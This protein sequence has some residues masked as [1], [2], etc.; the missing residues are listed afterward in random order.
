MAAT[1]S[2]GTDYINCESACIM[3]MGID[4]RTLN[5]ASFFKTTNGSSFR[6]RPHDETHR[7][8]IGSSQW[9]SKVFRKL[10]TPDSQQELCS[11]VSE[12][13]A[14]ADTKISWNVVKTVKLPLHFSVYHHTSITLRKRFVDHAPCAIT[15][16]PHTTSKLVSTKEISKFQ[17]NLVSSSTLH[18]EHWFQPRFRSASSNIA[19]WYFVSSCQT[20]TA[21]EVIQIGPNVYLIKTNRAKYATTVAEVDSC[22]ASTETLIVAERENFYE[23]LPPCS[24]RYTSV[25]CYYN[26]QLSDR[27]TTR[28]EAV[29][30]VQGSLEL[31][32]NIRAVAV[33]T[34]LYIY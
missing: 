13:L 4:S 23:I 30:T 5:L 28:L 17:R 27:H 26:G 1:S 16:S 33:W 6:W 3:W 14:L 2:P 32:V 12:C 18:T 8:G 24:D 11:Q 31:T 9:S 22:D 21:L 15:A 19:R 10:T 7:N 29:W 25:R 34:T 20:W